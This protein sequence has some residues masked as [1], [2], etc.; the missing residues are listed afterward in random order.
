MDGYL[1]GEKVFILGSGDIG[2]IMARR[3][4]LEGAKV[5]G[6][7]EIQRQPNGIT[8]NIVQCLHDFHIPLYLSH[9]VTRIYGKERIQAIELSQVDENLKPIEGTE[10]YIEVDALLLSIGLLPNNSLSEGVG[11]ALSKATKGPIVS[12]DL[13]TSIPGYFACG[14][15]LHVHDVVDYVVAEA[16]RCVDGVM[17]YLS[18]Q[19]SEERHIEVT[20]HTGL[21]YVV[22]QSIKPQTLGAKQRFYFRVKSPDHRVKIQIFADGMLIKESLKSHV[23]P[24]E[25][26]YIEVD[27]NDAVRQAQHI[28]LALH[29]EE[30]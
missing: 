22:P 3:M 4:T 28:T 14:N 1:V 17:H 24:A 27:I 6:V 30:A 13:Q 7:A 10:Q 5:V 2:L 26:E 23:V 19:I 8:R 21:H 15:V 29:K 16:R 9:T 20:A 11:I 12:N 25:M 18:N